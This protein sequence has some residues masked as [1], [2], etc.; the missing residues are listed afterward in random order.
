[1]GFTATS[2]PKQATA[3]R[4]GAN[5]PKSDHRS[6]SAEILVGDCRTVLSRLPA[7]HFAACVTSPPYYFVRDA[8]HP[9]QIGMEA[10]LN[11]YVR[12]LVGVFRQVRRVLRNDGTVWV[13]IDDLMCTRRA[14]RLDGKRIVAR[15]MARGTRSTEPWRDAAAAGRTLYSARMSGD[16]L[17]EK[18]LMLIPQ[19]LALALQADG[20]WV[21]ADIIWSKPSMAPSPVMDR[22]VHAYEHILP[23]SKRAHYYFDPAPLRERAVTGQRPGRDVCSIQPSR[24]RIEHSATFPGRFSRTLRR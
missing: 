20:W 11:D 24:E 3:A 10:T 18:D 9:D 2:R 4:N 16:G 1:M 12:A 17:K 7:D 19:R 21:R 6:V 13:V 5:G 22:P 15:D 8:D 23:L 14:V